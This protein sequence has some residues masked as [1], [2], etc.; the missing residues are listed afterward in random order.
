M[1]FKLN[2]VYW[3]LDLQ[4]LQV[5][6]IKK[7][8]LE[9]PL[10]VQTLRLP[11]A[12]TCNEISQVFPFC[13]YIPPVI[14]L[15]LFTYCDVHVAKASESTN[16]SQKFYTVNLV[17]FLV[18]YIFYSYSNRR[19]TTLELHLD[20]SNYALQLH[21]KFLMHAVEYCLCVTLLTNQF[22]IISPLCNRECLFFYC[23]QYKMYLICLGPFVHSIV[24]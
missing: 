10:C 18:L 24:D 21:I 20:V 14:R 9:I 13:T 11:Q 17:C 1:N 4:P 22:F 3:L 7:K 2:K 23:V 6:N 12:T 15:S 16:M 8:D 19:H 5:G